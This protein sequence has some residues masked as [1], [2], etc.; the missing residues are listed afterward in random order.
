MLYVEQVLPT[1][2]A[3]LA[4][5]EAVL[6][7]VEQGGP[8]KETLRI[9]QAHEP[10]IVLGR[11]SKVDTEVNRCAAAELGIPIIRRVSGGATVV[12]AAGCMFYSVAL[13]LAE[14]PHLR[15]LDEA[16]RYVITH[17]QR[18][19][20]PSVPN[21]QFEGT[22]DLVVAG[23]KVSG[24]SMRLLRN[25]LLYH[26]T[27]LLHMNLSLVDQLLKH[28]PREPDYRRGRKH[29]DFLANLNLPFE[30][31]AKSLKL[32]WQAETSC[33]TLPMDRVEQLVG[34][35]YSQASW[36]LCL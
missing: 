12:T 22:C 10:S 16:H 34:E 4:L 27:L 11:S 30:T 20:L 13:S 18:A 7:M 6:E 8:P 14:R 3:N 19:L 31:V 1:I 25:S 28:P 2:A 24:N 23:R 36:N 26:G 17:M 9:W 35:K 33:D 32:S 21:L 5:D 15:M 29:L